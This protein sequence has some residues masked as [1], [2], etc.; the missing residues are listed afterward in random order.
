[1]YWYGHCSTGTLT[2]YS[3]SPNSVTQYLY[4]NGTLHTGSILQ[5]SEQHKSTVVIHSTVVSSPSNTTSKEASYKVNEKKGSKGRM[6][7]I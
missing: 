2:W 1:M 6:K 7:K 3:N 4:R 5:L